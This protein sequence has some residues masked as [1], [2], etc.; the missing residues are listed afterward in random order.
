[1]NADEE[2]LIPVLESILN[3]EERPSCLYI[4]GIY[5]R[6]LP[7][8]RRD[9]PFHLRRAANPYQVLTII[10]EASHKLVFIEHDPSL[11]EDAAEIAE[12][13]G[14]RCDEICPKSTIV[15]FWP[16]PDNIIRKHLERSARRI[17]LVI[18]RKRK[19]ERFRTKRIFPDQTTLDRLW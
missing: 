19:K 14:K 18:H 1:M 8:L 3:R 17:T 4:C 5:P 9:N 6:I 7:K 11:Y 16:Y 12:E 10:N 2:L 15:Y 13:I